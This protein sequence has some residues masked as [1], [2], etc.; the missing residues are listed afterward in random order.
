[1]QCVCVKKRETVLIILTNI[2]LVLITRGR[3][4]FKDLK[5]RVRPGQITLIWF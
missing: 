2:V 4:R 1:M 3:R 5:L